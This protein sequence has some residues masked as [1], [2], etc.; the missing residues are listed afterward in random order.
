LSHGAPPFG[1]VN[2]GR[3]TDSAPKP[4]GNSNDAEQAAKRQRWAWLGIRAAILLVVALIIGALLVLTNQQGPA[5]FN[6][7]IG[8]NGE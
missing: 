5:A 7:I 1:D 6:N 3:W 8:G 4:A 2:A